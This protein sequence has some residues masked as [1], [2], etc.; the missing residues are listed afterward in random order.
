MAQHSAARA[1]VVGPVPS[2]RRRP[3]LPVSLPLPRFATQD[4]VLDPDTVQSHLVVTQLY[5][6][7]PGSQ[8]STPCFDL[9]KFDSENS[10]TALSVFLVFDVVSVVPE[11]MDMSR[12]AP[13]S[14]QSSPVST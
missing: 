1:P 11:E 14:P 4:F 5:P 9:A 7:S 10:R 8:S 13:L 12:F 2:D 6:A 3:T